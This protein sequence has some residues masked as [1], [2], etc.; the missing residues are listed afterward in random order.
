M[1]D[2]KLQ[3]KF[4]EGFLWGGAIAANQTEGAWL[5][6]GKKPQAT[7][8]MVGIITDGHTPGVKYNPQT[9][10]YEICLNPDKVYLA[11]EAI[12][13]YH[14]YKED[15]QLMAGM[16][17]NCFR[18]SISWARIFPNGDELAPNEAGLKHYD[19]LF[20]TML[21]LGMEPIV[22]ITHFDTPLHLMCEYNG[23]SN[24]KMIGFFLNYCNVIF[25]RYGAKVKYW[26]TFNEINNIFRMP[27]AA[28][29]VMPSHTDPDTVDFA[30]NYT[31]K[32]LHQ[33][34]HNA[35]VANAQCVRLFH[36][37]VP[38]GR[39]GCMIA[40]S[41]L[42]TYPASCD[43][44][45]VLAT[46]D[47]RRNTFLF[48][49]IMAAG[50]Y[51]EYLRKMW[52]DQGIQ[53]DIQEGELELIRDN[54]V[55][56]IGFSYYYSNVCNAAVG[57]EFFEG[58]LTEGSRK[59]KNPYIT[60]YSPSPWNFPLDPLGLRY[61]LEEYTDRYHKPLFI[62]ENGLGLDETEIPG[63]R[64]QDPE[65]VKFLEEHLKQVALAIEDGCNV[66]GY[67]WWGPLDLVSS[68]TGEMRKRY[69][70]VYVDRHNDGTGDLHRSIKESYYRYK[71][72][73]A[74]NGL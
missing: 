43:P 37:L 72:I 22:T 9:Q 56:Y 65:R 38:G 40:G 41:H 4:P 1:T 48:T 12:D 60:E 16:G 28:G 66:L 32:E 62:M 54:T 29:G 7:D 70:F 52:K 46:L 31:Q 58:T 5:E 19:D 57:A 11:H 42:A 50:V 45:D 35:M 34:L 44:R 21:S 59:V 39:I 8:V 69:G 2:R 63:Q 55:D 61:V 10:K 6:D 14:R 74:N 24:R 67:L 23:W 33:A 47:A 26:L 25:R 36:D 49:D 3:Y 17:M 64:I 15:L 68:G 51:P 20:D 18:T 27:F 30:A 53:P 71:E 13:F 73:I